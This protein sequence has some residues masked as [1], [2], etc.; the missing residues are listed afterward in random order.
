MSE[1]SQLSA[2]MAGSQ[3]HTLCHAHKEES[4]IEDGWE[5]GMA[6]YEIQN[7][8]RDYEKE[9]EERVR[10]SKITQPW[11]YETQ[12]PPAEPPDINY[13]LLIIQDQEMLIT[14][15]K[16]KLYTLQ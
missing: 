4:E 1:P 5:K 14:Y 3:H 12:K 13:R 10:A 7:S 9:K 2:A 15:W 16:M 6:E 11:L 8:R